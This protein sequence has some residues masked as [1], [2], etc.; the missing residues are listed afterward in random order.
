MHDNYEM[1]NCPDFKQ[2]KLNMLLCLSTTSWSSI[3]GV[4]VKL[5][6]L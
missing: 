5:H 4:E 6:A 3:M 2:V 1:L